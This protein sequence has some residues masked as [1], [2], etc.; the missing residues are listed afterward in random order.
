MTRNANWVINL[1]ITCFFECGQG[2]EKL[3]TA[4]E[5]EAKKKRRVARMGTSGRLGPRTVRVVTGESVEAVICRQ[6]GDDARENTA[7]VCKQQ[8]SGFPVFASGNFPRKVLGSTRGDGR[9][10]EELGE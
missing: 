4:L 8:S 10:A 9:L 3:R 7:E 1:N 5:T 2:G 6:V